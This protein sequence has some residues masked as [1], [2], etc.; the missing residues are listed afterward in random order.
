MP[1]NREIY[2]KIR[3]SVRLT[4]DINGIVGYHR[5]GYYSFAVSLYSKIKKEPLLERDKITEGMI[6]IYSNTYKLD[7]KILEIIAL[8]IISEF[9]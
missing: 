3:E 7:R 2:K 6:S 8:T 5:I 1:G 4:L 9:L